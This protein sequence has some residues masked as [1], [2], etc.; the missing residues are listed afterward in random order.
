MSIFRIGVP[1][2]ASDSDS[3]CCI[4]FREPV[5]RIYPA[6]LVP[7]ADLDARPGICHL[8]PVN[9]LLIFAG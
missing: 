2:N 5:R 1:R 6:S 3:L 9:S 8:R 4:A 7:A